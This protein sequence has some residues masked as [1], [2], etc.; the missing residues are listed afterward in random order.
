MAI[1]NFYILAFVFAAQSIHALQRRD[2]LNGSYSNLKLS[3]STTENTTDEYFNTTT[4]FQI[5]GCNREQQFLLNLATQNAVEL[6]EAVFSDSE[7]KKRDENISVLARAQMNFKTQAAIDY[8]GPYSQ[9]E[10]YQDNITS[11]SPLLLLLA[12]SIF[13]TNF[14]KDVFMNMARRTGFGDY[15]YDRRVILTC[16]D[17]KSDCKKA[18]PPAAYYYEPEPQDP[19]HYDYPTIVFCNYYFN[20]FVPHPIAWNYLKQHKEYQNNVLNLQ[21]Q[22]PSSFDAIDISSLED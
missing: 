21:S 22:G 14:L 4:S 8:F 3:S 13:M 19:A 16:Q 7:L 9:N 11:N 1:K 15:W 2:L 18:G 5:Y 6:T 17:I 12:G 20:P 10:I